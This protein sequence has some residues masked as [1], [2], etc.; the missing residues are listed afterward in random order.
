[1][2]PALA[3]FVIAVVLLAATTQAVTGFGFALVAMPLFVILLDVRDAVVLTALLA[4]VNAI[5]MAVRGRAD[6]P[7]STVGPLLAGAVAGMPFGLAVLL[8]VPADALRAGVGVVTL[9]MVAALVRGLR[10]GTRS[11]RSELAVGGAAGVLTTST[12]VNGPPVVLY[13]QGREHAPDEFRA[14]LAV[15]FTASGAISS[16]IFAASGVM[17]PHAVALWAIAVPFVF[18]GNGA[19]RRLAG[20]LKAEVFRRV[21]LV[22]LV[23]SACSALGAAIARAL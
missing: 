3:V 18:I 13:L 10:F 12:A 2:D 21:V 1:M 6:V 16:T 5:L 8:L 14:A 17:T 15:F 23:A 4:L 19:G 9:V 7:W 22:L 20:L 11:T